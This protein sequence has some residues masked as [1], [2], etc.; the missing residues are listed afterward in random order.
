MKIAIFHLGFFFSGGGEK[1]V[2]EEAFDLTKRGHEVALFAPVV[3][4]KACFPDLI[5][6]AKV[7]SLF[8]PFSF[9]FPL[10]DFLAIFGAVFLTPFTFWRFAKF[11]VFLELISRDL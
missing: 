9:N 3:D 5:K 10:R 2:L 7:H 11:D 6:K 1:L 4:K 8:F